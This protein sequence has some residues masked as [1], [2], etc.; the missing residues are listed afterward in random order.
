M[1]AR[2]RRDATPKQLLS[3][4]VDLP[5]HDVGWSAQV[6]AC[7]GYHTN[8]HKLGIGLSDHAHGP[9][10]KM[11]IVAGTQALCPD[12]GLGVPASGALRACA[13]GSIMSL[14]VP[15]QRRLMPTGI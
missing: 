4:R 2:R 1:S 9:C 12:A 11:L 8:A 14:G 13:R 10:P 7:V 3:S 15:G 5:A 6:S